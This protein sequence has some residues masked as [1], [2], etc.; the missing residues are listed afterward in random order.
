MP[1]YVLPEKY[2]KSNWKLNKALYKSKILMDDASLQIMRRLLRPLTPD[3]ISAIV[4]ARIGAQSSGERLTLADAGLE[5]EV[6]KI[7]TY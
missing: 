1:S 7:L 3:E 5:D 2:S 6:R 4:R